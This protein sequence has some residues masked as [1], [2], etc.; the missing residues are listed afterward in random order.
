MTE[1]IHEPARAVPVLHETEVL[2]A[3]AGIA[4]LFAALE[5]AAQGARTTLVDEYSMVGGNYGPGLGSRHDL[6]QSPTFRDRG[7]GGQVGAFLRE[8]ERRG[9][10]KTFDFISGG[11]NVPWRWQGMAPIPVIDRNE[12]QRLALQRLRELDVALLLSTTV[13]GA[14]VQNGAVGGVFVET[15][16]GR[17]AVRAQVVV[18]TTGEADVAAAAG[19]DVDASHAGTE[20]GMGLFFRVEGVDWERYEAFRAAERG[21]PLARAEQRWVDEVLVPAMDMVWKNYP[22]E[23]LPFIMADWASGAFRYVAPVPGG[24]YA[25]K[26]PFATHDQDVTTIEVRWPPDKLSVLNAL[27]RSTIEASARQH[28]YDTIDFYCRHV[29]GFEQARVSQTAPYMGNRWSRTIVPDYTLT[30]ED[31]VAERKFDDVVHVLTTL[32]RYDET[33]QQ[34]GRTRRLVDLKNREEG[35]NFDIPLRQF[36]PQGLDGMVAAGRSIG[37]ER[38]ASLRWRWIAKVTGGV[39]GLTAAVAAS[40]GAPARQMDI[41]TLQRALVAAGYYLGEPERLAELGIG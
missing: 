5:S 37:R 7:L 23:L 19:A 14:V 33:A 10:I 6:W 24:A 4:G 25:Y 40:A 35:H 32:Y 15:P 16:D 29:P 12:F 39:A 34:A 20:A 22:R 26:I 38:T 17:R 9:G 3:G 11:D 13:A 30:K 2:V 31:I 1:V 18:D 36:L 8:L 41:R 21:K 28:A 27:N